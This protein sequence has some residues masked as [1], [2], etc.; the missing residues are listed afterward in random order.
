[1]LMCTC[2]HHDVYSLNAHAQMLP[3]LCH[4]AYKPLSPIRNSIVQYRT[5]ER[6]HC[7]CPS[8]IVLNSNHIT[9]WP[10]CGCTHIV[11]TP[12]YILSSSFYLLILLFYFSSLFFLLPRFLLIHFTFNVRSDSGLH[13]LIFKAIIIPY[14]I[15][16]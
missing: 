9:I 4:Y 13:A 11:L 1:M 5:K 7:Y 15:K 6:H 16:I 10:I 14:V 8:R 2:T 12:V 3:R